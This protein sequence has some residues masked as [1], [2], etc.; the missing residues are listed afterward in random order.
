M[1][2]EGCNGLAYEEYLHQ[3]DCHHLV[4]LLIGNKKFYLPCSLFH[5]TASLISLPLFY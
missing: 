5:I 1:R 2:Y 3:K 4:R